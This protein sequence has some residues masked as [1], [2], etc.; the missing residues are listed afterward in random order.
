[1]VRRM[2]TARIGPDGRLLVPAGMRRDLGFKPGEALV[3]RSEDERL[4]VER[5]DAALR[6]LQRRFAA[7]PAEVSLVDELLAERERDRERDEG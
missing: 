1:M 6:R 4:I 7:V 2:V 3:L 5:R